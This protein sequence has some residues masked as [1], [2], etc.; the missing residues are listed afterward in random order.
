MIDCNI[1]NNQP[2]KDISEWFYFVHKQ[3]VKFAEHL[4]KEIKD[5][6]I[7]ELI[8][9]LDTLEVIQLTSPMSNIFPLTVPIQDEF[10]KN[11]Q[12]LKN[13]EPFISSWHSNLFLALS[14]CDAVTVY[15]YLKD[16]NPLFVYADPEPEKKYRSPDNCKVLP[17]SKLLYPYKKSL[18]FF[19]W[20][21]IYLILKRNQYVPS[22]SYSYNNWYTDWNRA[23][24][25]K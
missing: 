8:L 10:F 5:L 20:E 13:R 11:I 23:G 22:N 17:F 14:I 25:K 7:D 1:E 16:K 12:I 4:E 6:S 24:D 19:R 15:K 18:L 2:P 21:R 3:L 9:F